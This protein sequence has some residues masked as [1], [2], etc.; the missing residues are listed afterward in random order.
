MA[1]HIS[2]PQTYLLLHRPSCTQSSYARSTRADFVDILVF[3]N[4]VILVYLF[5]YLLLFIFYLAVLTPK[6]TF[7]TLENHLPYRTS[8]FG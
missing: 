5:I 8:I 2:H 1:D 6:T 7:Q 3:R 4:G